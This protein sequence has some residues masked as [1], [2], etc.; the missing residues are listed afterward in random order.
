MVHAEPIVRSGL[1]GLINSHPRLSV[2]GE[3]GNVR[4]VR[5]ICLRTLPDLVVIDPG[6]GGGEGLALFRDLPQCVPNTVTLAFAGSADAVDVQQVFQAGAS[7]YLTRDDT[8][9]VIL[10]AMVGA[11]AGERHFGT[12]VE[13]VLIERLCAGSL[14]MRD[15]TECLL[16]GRERQVFHLLGTGKTGREIAATLGVSVKTVESHQERMKHKLGCPSG[17]VLRQ[18]AAHIR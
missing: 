12:G 14:E 3:T 11:V 13:R 5:A 9:A 10:G 1:V 7:A 4:E 17:A 16:T 2:V 18:R 6:I 8:A 15:S